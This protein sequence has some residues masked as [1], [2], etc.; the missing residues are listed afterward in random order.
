MAQVPLNKKLYDMVVFQAKR[1]YKTYPNP[2]ASHWVHKRYVELG[3]RFE[4][5]SEDSKRKKSARQMFQNKLKE[6]MANKDHDAR[7]SKKDEK[8]EDK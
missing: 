6:K 4:D 2:G 8:N 7:M 5:T 3:G 1:K